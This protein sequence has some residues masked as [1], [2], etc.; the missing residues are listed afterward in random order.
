NTYNFFA[1]YAN[2]D[3]FVDQEEAVANRPE[4]DRWILSKLNSLVADVDA[5][6]AAYEPTRA[7]RLIQEFVSDELS[8]WYVRLCRRRFWKGEYAEDKISAYQ[9]LHQCLKKVAIMAAPIAPFYMD[10]LYTDLTS[11]TH[12]KI[13]S[14]HL[15]DFPKVDELQIDVD[16]EQRMHIAQKL[17]SMVLG[18][19]KKERLKVRQPL[20]KIMV[21]ILDATFERQLQAVEDLVLAEVNVKELEYLRD[22]AGVLVKRI[23]PNFKALGPK[24]GKSMKAASAAI[25]ALGQE[26][27]S[28]LERTGELMINVD[29][30]EFRLEPSDVEILTDDIPGW[31]VSVDGPITVAL[32]LTLNAELIEE[33]IARELVNRIQNLRK[34]SGLELTDRIALYIKKQD[35]INQAVE[36]NLKYISAE[37]LAGKLELVDTIDNG[38]NVEVDDNLSTE[39]SIQRFN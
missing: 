38:L 11:G 24:F 27:I 10:Q 39:I 28:I 35:G 20:Q 37:T 21:P 2:I 16:L 4:I 26:Q 15:A 17:T 31:T 32:D 14:V 12:E 8:N 6:Y 7:G 23:K 25:N 13:D 5:A 19:R 29:G 34:D 22:T 9:T 1:L 18:I 30:Q 33:G 36:N 3:G